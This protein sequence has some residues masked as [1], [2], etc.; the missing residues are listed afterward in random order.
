[1]VDGFVDGELAANLAAGPHFV[2][3]Q[4][5]LAAQVLANDW[6]QIAD[7]NAVNMETPGNPFPARISST[8]F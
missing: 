5:S 3:H 2:R 1:V 7:A 4:A 8:D 6:L